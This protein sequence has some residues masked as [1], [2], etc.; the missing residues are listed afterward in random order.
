MS[1]HLGLV[2][3]ALPTSAPFITQQH[4]L[5]KGGGTFQEKQRSADTLTNTPNEPLEA[6]SPATAATLLQFHSGLLLE[7]LLGKVWFIH[8]SCS[9]TCSTRLLNLLGTISCFLNRSLLLDMQLAGKLLAGALGNSA[10]P[11]QHGAVYRWRETWVVVGDGQG[12]VLWPPSCAGKGQS[13]EP[14]GQKTSQLCLLPELSR[15]CLLC[16]Q[17]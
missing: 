6:S 15:I 13:H 7:T 2:S 9:F 14:A 16:L 17:L 8:S 4:S 5:Q 1:Q 11:S 3:S 12:G 10:L